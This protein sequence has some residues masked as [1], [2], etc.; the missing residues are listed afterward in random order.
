MSKYSKPIIKFIVTVSLLF[1]NQKFN[2]CKYIFDIFN[3][4][5]ENIAY[6]INSIETLIIS[7][8]PELI[9]KLYT[10]LR[11]NISI[12]YYN[13]AEEQISNLKF[14]SKS[15][16]EL[17]TKKFHIKLGVKY[18]RVFGFIFNCLESY[19]FIK[20]NPKIGAF[21]LEEGYGLSNDCI[22]S[23]KNGVRIYFIKKFCP[24][25][26]ITYVEFKLILQCFSDGE[27]EVQASLKKAGIFSKLCKL[28]VEEAVIESKINNESV[29]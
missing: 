24:S 21:E 14:N 23:D 26:K 28:K 6:F 18:S 29:V 9:I 8:V 5:S 27:A 10:V 2:W 17:E 20:L 7:V 3:I 25:N 12:F 1:L 16:L 11:P 13:D 22:R 15:P 4:R 19:I